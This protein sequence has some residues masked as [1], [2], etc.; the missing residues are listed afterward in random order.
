MY[1]VNVKEKVS[2]KRIVSTFLL[3]NIIQRTDEVNVSQVQ[4]CCENTIHT[5]NFFPRE[6]KIFKTLL[7]PSELSLVV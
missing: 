7:D 4:N 5:L 3:L 6:T 2:E 1:I